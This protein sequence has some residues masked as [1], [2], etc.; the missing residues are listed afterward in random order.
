[1]TKFI[2]L[3]SVAALL[4]VSVLGSAQALPPRQ[5]G[6]INV[7]QSGG[8][9]SLS[10]TAAGDIDMSTYKLRFALGTEALP[11]LTP[12][13]DPDTGIS[14]TADGLNF[15]TGGTHRL[16]LSTTLMTAGLPIQGVAGTATNPAYAG[17]GANSDTGVAF[18]ATDQINFILNGVSRHRIDPTGYF[19][20]GDT[21]VLNSDTRLGGTGTAVGAIGRINSQSTGM[22][23]STA[24]SNTVNIV[25]A[26][27]Y[28]ANY[29]VGTP[30]NPVLRVHSNTG[31]G[32]ATNQYI[33]F[34]HDTTNG[35]ITT[36]LGLVSFPNGLATATASPA[37][38]DACT[39]G[40][41]TWDASYIYVCTASGAWK[42]SAL[43][44]GY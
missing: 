3:L 2:S 13:G 42:R 18:L 23:I 14:A 9:G 36:G 8:G 4:Q 37:S 43:T 12:T 40:R 28:S 32:T 25:T 6:V 5:S 35:V 17:T 33:S 15:S 16:R 20:F 11:G 27:N 44:G 34:S 24:T 29:S 39:A 26:A 41:I 1:M 10:G 38:G 31:S 30:T 22:N 19:S 21:V 7:G